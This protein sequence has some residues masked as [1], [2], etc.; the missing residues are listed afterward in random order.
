MKSKAKIYYGMYLGAILQKSI[1]SFEKLT[2]KDYYTWKFENKVL[3]KIIDVVQA[4][5]KNESKPASAGLV[6]ECVEID[7]TGAKFVKCSSGLMKIIL[8]STSEQIN[9]TEREISVSNAGHLVNAL[10]SIDFGVDGVLYGKLAS[11]VNNI[12]CA[13]TKLDL[14]DKE[15]ENKTIKVSF[16]LIEENE[17]GEIEGDNGT[18][19]I[20]AFLI[21]A[22]KPVEEKNEPG[23]ETTKI[24][25]GE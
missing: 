21:E 7:A 20:I 8:G 2:T 13:L 22:G 3:Q 25:E 23:I 9:G 18:M 6:H 1:E 17:I 15:I 14:E 5:E 16:P 19:N 24:V 12:G 11:I 4:F 10:L